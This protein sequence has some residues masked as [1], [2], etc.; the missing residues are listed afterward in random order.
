MLNKIAFI[1]LILFIGYIS[2]C[3]ASDIDYLGEIPEEI[4]KN[5]GGGLVR[6]ILT[7]ENTPVSKSGKSLK[8]IAKAKFLSHYFVAKE[9][10]STDEDFSLLVEDVNEDDKPITFL[11]WVQNKY[12]LKRT[13][14]IRNE[15]NI[16][17]KILVINKWELAKKRGDSLVGAILRKGP[18][19]EFEK[20]KELSI[21]RFYYLYKELEIDGKTWYLVGPQPTVSCYDKSCIDLSI[22]GWIPEEKV[23]LW[24]TGQAIQYNKESLHLAANPRK[25][26][27]RIYKSYNELKKVYLDGEEIK[28]LSEEDLSRGEWD[29]HWM[30]FPLL[31]SVH[32]PRKY[33]ITDKT[34][35]ELK[36]LKINT[37][38]LEE[39]LLNKEFTDKD[40]F[41]TLVRPRIYNFT[42]TR[43]KHRT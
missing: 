11:G 8:E 6:R 39:D 43:K 30:R 7:R 34:I 32:F 19:E 36:A 4:L 17:R 15:L 12:L 2:G 25:T 28:P 20:N 35:V 14:A 41:L 33:K 22:Y 31:D 18:G 42:L 10:G 27:A 9:S 5:K 3:L 29:Y 40:K 16:L 23:F 38:Q 13:E 37:K 21:F 24:E 1:K 26:P